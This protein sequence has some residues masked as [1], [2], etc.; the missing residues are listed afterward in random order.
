MCQVLLQQLLFQGTLAVNALE[1]TWALLCS[2][3]EE[4]LPRSKQVSKPRSCVSTDHSDRLG[5][6]HF[7]SVPPCAET[8]NCGYV[9]SG[10]NERVPCSYPPGSDK[11]VR[12]PCRW[13]PHPP[14]FSSFSECGSGQ[15]REVEEPIALSHGGFCTTEFDLWLLHVF[16]SFLFHT[17]LPSSNKGGL[18]THL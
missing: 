17:A 7:A 8:P 18:A 15:H 14:D 13:S 11:W 12:W 2:I 3:I 10:A 9:Q 1:K 4:D 6:K 5:T 16:P